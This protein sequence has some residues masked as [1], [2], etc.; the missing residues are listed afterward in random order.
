MPWQIGSLPCT[1]ADAPNMAGP[2][3][4]LL[5]ADCSSL[6]VDD[7]DKDLGRCRMGYLAGERRDRGCKEV[8]SATK[9]FQSECYASGRLRASL[10]NKPTTASSRA[11]RGKRWKVHRGCL[12]SHALTFGCGRALAVARLGAIERLDLAFSAPIGG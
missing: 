4:R 8:P 9:P 3:L 6:I 7:A 2:F 1:S 5:Q 10:A 12:S 11:G